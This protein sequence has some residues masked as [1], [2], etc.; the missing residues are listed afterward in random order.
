MQI[1]ERKMN[2]TLSKMDDL[3]YGKTV[4]DQAEAEKETKRQARLQA[5]QMMEQLGQERQREVDNK[6]Q[7]TRREKMDEY[8]ADKAKMEADHQAYLAEQK[9]CRDMAMMEEDENVRNS[10][11]QV[12]KNMDKQQTTVSWQREVK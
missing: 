6:L 12:V 7:T 10:Y 1:A 8:A 11:L 3:A 5:K 2:S 4:I 9:K